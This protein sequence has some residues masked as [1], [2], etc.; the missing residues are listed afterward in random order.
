[1]VVVA[2]FNVLPGLPLDGGR[3]LRAVVWAVTGRRLR[4]TLVAARSGQV[5]AV[6][7]LGGA[8]AL[9]SNATL[10]TF[11]LV[12][13]LLV[14]LTLWQGASGSAQLA[15]VQQRVPLLDLDRL[16]RPIFAVPTGTPLAEAQ[17]RADESAPAGAAL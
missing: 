11:G 2:V 6:L 9:W 13:M 8:V 1:N 16:A 12:F 3:A 5:L 4:G 14:A 7:T 15:Q 10:T 17:R